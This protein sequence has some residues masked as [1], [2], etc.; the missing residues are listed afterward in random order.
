[1]NK[2]IYF[3]NNCI[4]QRYKEVKK[5]VKKRVAGINILTLL[6]ILCA[7]IPGANHFT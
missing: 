7:E 4:K 1:M 3:K 2:E 5:I 6:I